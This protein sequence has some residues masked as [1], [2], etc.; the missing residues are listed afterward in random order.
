MMYKAKSGK[1][2]HRIE[3]AVLQRPHAFF[4]GN[5]FFQPKRVLGPVDDHHEKEA[6]AI[7]ERV[8]KASFDTKHNTFFAPAQFK[9]SPVI[10]SKCASCGEE[11]KLQRKE[12]ADELTEA[13][14]AVSD[15][16]AGSGDPMDD[17][18]RS[19]MENRFMYDFSKVKIH[20][21]NIAAKSA[22]SINALAYTSGSD[23]VFNNDQYSPETES[24]KKLLAHELTHVVQQNNGRIGRKL[25]QRTVTIGPTCNTSDI[26]D[27]VTEA[28]TWLDDIYSQLD[29]KS[30]V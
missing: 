16:I 20:T 22:Q 19:F 21:G 10:Q 2:N 7:A 26:T 5:K 3:R 8:T 14:S 6:D 30:V 27:I 23:I 13:P 1:N 24:G 9:T 4:S 29:R 12:T 25:L 18:T 15:T 17:N 28:L 11:D